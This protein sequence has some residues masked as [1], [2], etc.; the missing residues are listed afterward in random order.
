MGGLVRTPRTGPPNFI[1]G[2]TMAKTKAT[3]KATGKAGTAD[4]AAKANLLWLALAYLAGKRS[5]RDAAPNNSATPIAVDVVG[6]FG[7]SL[8][9]E[10]ISGELRIGAPTNAASAAAAPT[11]HVV[12]LVLR[13]LGDDNAQAAVMAKIAKQFA[14]NG[15]LP[16]V[17]IGATE[18]ANAWLKQLRSQITIQKRGSLVFQ[19]HEG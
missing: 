1:Q 5:D 15:Y 12:A 13:E 14:Q 11:D 8:I 19:I 4:K 2:A 18:R 9:Q 16:P 10:Q 7:R 17:D 6:K 3:T